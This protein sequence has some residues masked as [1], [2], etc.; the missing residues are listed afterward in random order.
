[1]N[2]RKLELI[3]LVSIGALSIT[4][5]GLALSV[6]IETTFIVNKSGSF[7]SISIL[8]AARTQPHE[9]ID[10]VTEGDKS[11]VYVD[12]GAQF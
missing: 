9:F 1:M 5:V 8:P 3:G 4:A 10:N 2:V 7:A 12:L 6:Q 11:P